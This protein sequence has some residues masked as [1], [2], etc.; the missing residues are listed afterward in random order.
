MRT[1]ASGHQMADK[2]TEDPVLVRFRRMSRAR[3]LIYGRPRTFTALAIGIASIFVLPP[4][5]RLVTRLLIGWDVFAALYLV[6]VYG[7][8][9]GKRGHQ[10]VR[11]KAA[12]Q[13]G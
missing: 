1:S 4:S 7:M 12:Q 5:L 8:M 3:R 13:E 9:L 2:E 10:K 6:L 11:P